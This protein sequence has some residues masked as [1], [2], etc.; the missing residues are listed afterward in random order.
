MLTL[1]KV[2]QEVARSSNFDQFNDLD[3]FDFEGLDIEIPQQF[4]PPATPSFATPSQAAFDGHI[5]TFEDMFFETPQVT[6][7]LI[8]SHPL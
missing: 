3:N 4:E 6:F 8:L 2:I 5:D 7:S 1:D